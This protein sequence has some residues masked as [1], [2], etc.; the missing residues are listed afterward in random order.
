MEKTLEE[1]QRDV[2]Q[3]YCHKLDSMKIENEF[4]LIL[5]CSYAGRLY[6]LGIEQYM[7]KA[8]DLL[9][10][11][12]Y[13]NDVDQI[14]LDRIDQGVWDLQEQ[15]GKEIGISLTE[16]QDM[17]SF[18]TH[19]SYPFSDQI[20]QY[21]TRWVEAGRYADVNAE[22]IN[23]INEFFDA[24]PLNPSDVLPELSEPTTETIRELEYRLSGIR[25]TECQPEQ[26]DGGWEFSDDGYKLR[27][28]FKPSADNVLCF[29]VYEQTMDGKIA[30]EGV[31]IRQ[32]MLSAVQ[33]PDSPLNWSIGYTQ[34]P[35]LDVSKW[36]Q[37]PLT[38]RFPMGGVCKIA[39]PAS[40]QGSPYIANAEKKADY[41]QSPFERVP[42]VMSA[43]DS[44]QPESF[45]MAISG[46]G[47]YLKVWVDKSAKQIT[48]QARSTQDN[49]M[50]D[51]LRGWSLYGDN[52]SY[53]GTFNGKSVTYPYEEDSLPVLLEDEGENPYML[54]I[55][56]EN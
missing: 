42:V 34:I 19:T 5:Y 15:T 49:R 10:N 41:S 2:Q 44:D 28:E 52:G 6:S 29:E 48:V 47:V 32:G 13:S 16:L 53:L 25:Y 55:Q 8:D 7:P 21:F 33:D 26:I 56:K 30:A 31:T 38:I 37:E 9:Y 22:T 18:L 40:A 39:V 4:D 46:L 12:L 45:Q 17:H 24:N 14:F 23:Y 35:G 51:A 1:I 54:T 20:H 3:W 11:S 43:A 50:T 27:L 36:K